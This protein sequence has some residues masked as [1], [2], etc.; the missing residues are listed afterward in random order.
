M[1][2]TKVLFIDNGI[3]FDSVLFREKALGGAEVAFVS[4][5]EELAKLNLEVVVYNNCR[6]QGLI[7]N[8]KWK[9]LNE[10]IFDENFDVLVVNRGDKFLNFKKDCKKRFFW[11]HNPAKYLLKFRYL[12]KLFLNKFNIIFSS[13]Y[14]KSTYPFWAPS[15]KRI[16]IPYGID[17]KILKKRKKKVP[18]PVAI[19]TSNPLRD[20]DWLL[21]NWKLRIY[22]KVQNA[23]LNLFTGITTYGQF[24]KKHSKS[25]EKI[26]NKA[27][28]LKDYG[29][30][31]YK[32]L[33]R[34]ELFKKINESRIFL[35]KGTKDET[36]CMAAAEAQALGIPAVVCDFGSMKE[37][38]LD[39]KTGFVCKSDEQFNLKAIKLL[40]DDKIWMRMHKNLLKNDNHFRWSEIAKKWKKIIN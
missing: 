26:L 12:S 18:N 23:K 13:E 2:M 20:L 40:N 6:N 3:E 15:A 1:K 30:N 9:K 25:S 37:R 10:K 34:E 21:E 36:F 17:D 24:G 35:Y 33:R 28:S 19:F 38:I 32:P 14:H 39:N 11:I 8:V 5:V 4:L 7:K 31:L 16:V 22:P 27:D 29:V